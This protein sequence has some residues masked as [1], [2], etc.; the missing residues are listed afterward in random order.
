MTALRHWWAALSAR[1][2]MLIRI[3]LAL[4]LV[5][6]VLLAVVRPLAT[7]VTDA[8]ARLA[9]AERLHARALAA[10]SGTGQAARTAQSSLPLDDRIRQSAQEA[11]FEIAQLAPAPDGGAA[12]TLASARGPALYGWIGALEGRGVIVRSARIDPRSDATLAVSLELEAAR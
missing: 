10:T 5:V 12:V 7:Y 1:E 2:Q 9:S 3:M 4:A 8:P 6:A 11:G